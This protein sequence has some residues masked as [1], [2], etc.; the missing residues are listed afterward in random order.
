MGKVH[1]HRP[2]DQMMVVLFEL[3]QAPG[4]GLKT[5]SEMKTGPALPF[6]VRYSMARTRSE[7]NGFV[8]WC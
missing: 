8:L 6:L 5:F 7:Y 1:R 2:S 4:L 3:E